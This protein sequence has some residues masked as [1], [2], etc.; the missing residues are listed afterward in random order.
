MV[1]VVVADAGEVEPL[2]MTELIACN[3]H[4][5]LD[6]KLNLCNIQRY[7]PITVD[8]TA[9]LYN[10]IKIFDMVVRQKRNFKHKNSEFNSVLNSPF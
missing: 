3:K 2:W 1:T 10:I 9:P 7:T 8:K 6:L 5:M 4:R